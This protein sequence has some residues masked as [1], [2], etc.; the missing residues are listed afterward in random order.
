MCNKFMKYNEKE[1]IGHKVASG[2]VCLKFE[3]LNQVL[4]GVA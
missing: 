4:M 1:K 3:L 2:I